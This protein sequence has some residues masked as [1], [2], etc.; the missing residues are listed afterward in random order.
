MTKWIYENT[1][2]VASI[3]LT[4]ATLKNRVIAYIIVGERYTHIIL[5]MV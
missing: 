1:Y 3:I 2:R 4:L 5:F